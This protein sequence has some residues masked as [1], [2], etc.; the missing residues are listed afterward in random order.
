MPKETDYKVADFNSFGPESFQQR[1]AVFEKTSAAKGSRNFVIPGKK[2]IASE[3]LV[4]ASNS[5]RGVD[6]IDEATEV[7]KLKKDVQKNE[8]ARPE[9]VSEE[10]LKHG[11]EMLKEKS[12]AK[13]KLLE[14]ERRQQELVEQQKER[15]RQEKI[16]LEERKQIEVLAQ[17]KLLEEERLRQ[18]QV[19][20]QEKEVAKQALLT[21]QKIRE[22]Q[23]G[24]LHE[25]AIRDA[26]LKLDL[27]DLEQRH[28]AFEKAQK[29]ERNI[30]K[31][32]T[33]KKL[34]QKIQRPSSAPSYRSASALIQPQLLKSEAAHEELQSAPASSARSFST[35]HVVSSRNFGPANLV[36]GDFLSKIGSKAF[37]TRRG[38]E[39]DGG[40]T[41]DIHGAKDLKSLEKNLKEL[42]KKSG[43]AL[44]YEKTSDREGM[45]NIKLTI[46]KGFSAKELVEL[47]A[48]LGD[49]K[50]GK[51]SGESFRR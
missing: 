19:H 41:F 1:K 44:K 32:A 25:K 11:L 2:Q 46:A 3:Q 39:K 40:K 27:R 35:S 48:N 24:K 18:E 30:L 17:K 47:V 22:E 13:Q 12:L 6:E 10:Q 26:R 51:K 4:K 21:Q 37:C 38:E 15:I 31:K 34:E 14:Q 50:E 36:V 7:S 29:T 43:G 49:Q 20:E 33:E 16:A 45:S 23:E 8:L 9:L 5:P 28:E 42:C